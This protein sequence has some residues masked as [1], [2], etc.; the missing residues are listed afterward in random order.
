MVVPDPEQSCWMRYHYQVKSLDD[1][2]IVP[3]MASGA[4]EQKLTLWVN[5]LNI[6]NKK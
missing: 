3:I 6:S 1:N 4:F 2:Y 5:K